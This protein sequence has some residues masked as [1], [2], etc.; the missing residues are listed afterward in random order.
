MFCEHGIDVAGQFPVA[1]E[2][3]VAHLFISALLPQP[4]ELVV[5]IEDQR[6]M[7]KATGGTGGIGV[8]ADH[9]KGFTTKAERK[10]RIFRIGADPFV[11]GLTEPGILVG[12]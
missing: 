12:H 9:E 7:R 4:L 2:N 6:R 3:R 1:I 8:Q 5:E 10:M 11:L